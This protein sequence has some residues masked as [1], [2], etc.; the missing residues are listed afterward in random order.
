VFVTFVLI[1]KVFF[2]RKIQPKS[3]EKGSF[4]YRLNTTF[5]H[6]SLTEFPS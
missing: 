5:G 4:L 2:K 6:F 1:F 3:A